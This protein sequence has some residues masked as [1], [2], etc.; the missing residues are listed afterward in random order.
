LPLGGGKGGIK[1]NPNEVSQQELQ[2]ITRR[3]FHA[4]G[5]NVGPETDIPAP[6]VGTDAKTMAWAM[7]TYMN[8]VG[9]LSKQAVKGVVTGGPHPAGCTTTA[10]GKWAN[11]AGRT[12]ARSFHLHSVGVGILEQ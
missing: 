3:F 11:A 8:T 5:S 12:V 7:D 2:R 9:Q 10:R 6:D 1:F 4:L